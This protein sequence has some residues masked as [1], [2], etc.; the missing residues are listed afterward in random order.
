M[1]GG[2]GVGGP[3]AVE[4]SFGFITVTNCKACNCSGRVEGRRS[5]GFGRTSGGKKRNCLGSGSV[6]GERRGRRERG[7]RGRTGFWA[8]ERR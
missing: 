6:M 2:G 1:E 4:S 3:W 8:F 5:G 7:R